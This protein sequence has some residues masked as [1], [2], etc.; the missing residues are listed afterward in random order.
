MKPKICLIMSDINIIRFFLRHQLLE[1]STKFDLTIVTYEGGE[2]ELAELGVIAELV[3]IRIEQKKITIFKD[4]MA[5]VHVYSFL[6]NRQFSLVQSY[7]SKPG[8][9]AMWAAKLAGV[10]I[11]LHWYIG[12]V[13]AT[14]TGLYRQ[15]LKAAD[16]LT[17]IAAT[18]LL[19]DS[20]SQL[21]FLLKEKITTLKKATVLLNGSICGVDCKVF[22]PDPERRKT[23]REEWGIPES[24]ILF[25]YMCRFTK[26]KGAVLCA[27]AFAQFAAN[28]QNAY[29]MMVGPD[30]EN[31]VPLI[32]KILSPI[33][34][35]S[36]IHGFTPQPEN[37]FC[38]ADVCCLPSFR[39]GFGQVLINA[40]ASG[41]PV[42]ASRIYG[43]IDA[44]VEG[45]TAILH[46]PGNLAQIVQAMQLIYTDETLRINLGMAGRERTTNHFSR[47][48]IT[49]A[50]I[51]H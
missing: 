23:I 1:F 19:V 22:Q 9:V 28:A 14:K 33:A 7:A 32:R 24:A 41:L 36:L 21:D 29:I 51:D 39:E 38:A 31:L 3:H 45:E 49:K 34:K 37:Y 26:D 6:R 42:I 13:W 15:L 4:I 8:L 17:S 27:E 30:D 5:F 18:N 12:Q 43:I 44:V 16:R 20:R 48:L 47:E 10:P 35:R 50:I 46:E 11:R 2:A 25:L 40:G